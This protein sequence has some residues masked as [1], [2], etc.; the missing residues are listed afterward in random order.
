MFFDIGG[1]QVRVSRIN[2]EGDPNM[3][4]SKTDQSFVLVWAKKRIAASLLGNRCKRCGESDIRCLEFHHPNEKSAGINSIKWSRWS[5]IEAE[6]KKCELLCSNCHERLHANPGRNALARQNLLRLV[7]AKACSECG[8]TDIGCSSLEF[9]HHG[10]KAFSIS[11]LATRQIKADWEDVLAELDKCTVICSNCHAKKHVNAERLTRLWDVI[12]TRMT[13]YREKPKP[14]NKEEVVRL[15]RMGVKQIVIA[16]RL[17]NSKGAISDIVGKLCPHK[18]RRPADR[19]LVQ[20]LRN[21][22]LTQTE[23]AKQLGY[24]PSTISRILGETKHK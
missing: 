3:Q 16:K 17:G 21:D 23:I 13:S 14:A 1:F 15:Y 24:D 19:G 22:G 18:V 8:H 20:S 10:D 12:E 9:H 5:V 6:V 4:L 11:A 7:G 2:G